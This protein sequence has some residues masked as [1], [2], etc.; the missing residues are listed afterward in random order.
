[1]GQPTSFVLLR[2][3]VLCFTWAV[4]KTAKVVT[5][6]QRELNC[7]KRTQLRMVIIGMRCLSGPSFLQFTLFII[8]TRLINTLV[9]GNISSNTRVEK[10]T[11]KWTFYIRTTITMK[12][13]PDTF[14]LTLRRKTVKKAGQ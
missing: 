11:G 3:F 8:H 10:V 2:R 12:Y 1:M 14:A 9:I 6:N 4:Q 7:L 13:L 5:I